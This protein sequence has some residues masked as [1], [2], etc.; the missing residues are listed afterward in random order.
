MNDIEFKDTGVILRSRRAQ[1]QRPVVLDIMQEGQRS[2]AD[3]H[4]D[5]NS[6]P[7]G[8][9]AVNSSV[10]VTSGMEIVLG[11]LISTRTRRREAAYRC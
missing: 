10:A 6:R 7:S 8:S 4:V 11:G 9:G 3:D 2:G 5:L 1:R